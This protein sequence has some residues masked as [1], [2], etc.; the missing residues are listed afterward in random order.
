MQ[1]RNVNSTEDSESTEVA[2][3]NLKKDN[4]SC[5]STNKRHLWDLQVQI[6]QT[7]ETLVLTSSSCGYSQRPANLS[8]HLLIFIIQMPSLTKGVRFTFQLCPRCERHWLVLDWDDTLNQRAG[9]IAWLAARPALCLLEFVIV[10]DS[11]SPLSNISRQK[12]VMVYK[13]LT[14]LA[15]VTHIIIT[16]KLCKLCGQLLEYVHNMIYTES[17]AKIV[18]NLK[19]TRQLLQFQ[20]IHAHTAE[21]P[22][23]K[24]SS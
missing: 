20:R 22:K 10:C 13:E 5:W 23:Q 9:L 4:V 2:K 8:I 19:I 18:T 3:L 12:E 24:L 14:S 21:W 1:G 11:M 6:C 16:C 17:G 15:P 7:G